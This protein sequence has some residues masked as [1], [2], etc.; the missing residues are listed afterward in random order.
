M[1]RTRAMLLFGVMVWLVLE[2][3][4][5]VRGQNA[6]RPAWRGRPALASRG[7]PGLALLGYGASVVS[8]VQG[9][10]T[11]ATIGVP[12]EPAPLRGGPLQ[13]VTVEHQGRLLVLTYGPQPGA[14]ALASPTST[15]GEPP[16]FVI[17]QGW[18]QIASGQFEYG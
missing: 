8:D 9:Q 15:R 7:H 11:S 13:P 5:L 3:T 18:R 2:S 14:G 10:D 17:Y 4:A 12:Q 6:A 16:R 1:R